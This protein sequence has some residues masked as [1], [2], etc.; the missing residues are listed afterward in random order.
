MCHSHYQHPFYSPTPVHST[1]V[2][3]SW[4]SHKWLLTHESPRVT[5]TPTL[6]QVTVCTSSD[7]YPPLP[8]YHEGNN[9]GAPSS[10]VVWWISGFPG[11][12]EDLSYG[13]HPVVQVTKTKYLETFK[14]LTRINKGR[15]IC[16][17]VVS[18]W[19]CF[20]HKT[21][22]YNWTVRNGAWHKVMRQIKY[23]IIK[24]K[25]I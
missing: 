5:P 10:C 18:I 22:A 8:R 16:V 12:V 24:D 11:I 2:T 15:I 13:N 4:M 14:L 23:I 9:G 7:K 21:V 1:W 6:C 17:I 25:T 20:S 19:F 3:C